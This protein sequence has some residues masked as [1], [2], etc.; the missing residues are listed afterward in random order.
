MT[1]WVTESLTNWLSH[2]LTDWV[3]KVTD[4]LSFVF[5]Y[6]VWYFPPLPSF[7]H[8]YTHTFIHTFIEIG[9]CW[10]S[11]FLNMPLH[12]RA[13]LYVCVCVWVCVYLFKKFRLLSSSFNNCDVTRLLVHRFYLIFI[14][15]HFVLPIQQY[16]AIRW[17]SRPLSFSTHTHTD[18]LTSTYIHSYTYL[19]SI[20]F[21]LIL[22][23]VL[24]VVFW[25]YVCEYGY[26]F[27]CCCSNTLAMMLIMTHSGT[28]W[29]NISKLSVILFKL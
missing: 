8:T 22:L 28:N 20:L 7:I 14:S 1:D 24:F 11:S 16:S 25:C 19:F 9:F 26:T 21:N 5:V 18:T 23:I 6:A 27:K 13:C 12:V 2:S 15:F 4:M 29:K 17:D 10:E 3:A